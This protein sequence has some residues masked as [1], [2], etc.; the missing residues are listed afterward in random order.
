MPKVTLEGIFCRKLKESGIRSITLQ[1]LGPCNLAAVR[2]VG[3]DGWICQ[4]RMVEQVE[5]VRTELKVL[6]AERRKTL[7]KRYVQ[8]VVAWTVDQIG[9]ATEVGQ[10]RVAGDERALGDHISGQWIGESA[11]VIPV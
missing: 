9:G 1:R 11:G 8:A 5:R 3:L 10:S 2:V 6:L 7:E 4:G